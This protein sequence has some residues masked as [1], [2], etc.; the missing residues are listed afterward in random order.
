MSRHA[1][2]SGLPA[3]DE[4][5]QGIR[6]GDNVVWKVEH[7]ED[8]LFFA[9]SF[10]RQSLQARRRVVYL[11]FA[12]H[13][14][15][16]ADW[17]DVERIELDPAP[18]FDA[19]SAELHRIITDHGRE[20]FYV[21]DNLSDLAVT[22]ATDEMLSNFFS[23]TCP[24]LFELDTVAYFA[25]TRG[26]HAGRTVASIRETTQLL[27]D[28]FHIGEA[29][30]LHPL[31][32]WDRY[33]PT[34]FLPHAVNGE[35]WTPVLHS[36]EATALSTHAYS[37]PLRQD[38]SS[39]APWD[40]VY[41]KLSQYHQREAPP[42]LQQEIA[43][44]E[45]ELAI[46]LLGSH[47][48]MHELAM[49]FLGRNELLAIRERLIGSGRIGGKATGMLVA[50]AIL[51]ANIEDPDLAAQLEGHDS[52]YIGSDVF[53]TFLVQNDLFRL[54]LRMT[55]TS[56][57]TREEF[58]V[59]ET[60]FL[61]GRFPE[62]IR[63]QFRHML[64][65]Y[66]QAPIIV[67]SSSLLEDSFGNAFAGKYRS[68]FLANQGEPEERLDQFERQVKLVYASALNPDALAYRKRHGLGDRDEQMAILVQRVSGF[69]LRRYFF[70]C[71]AGVAFS[72][73]MY[74]WADCIDPARGIIRLV[75][76]L[77]TRAVDR[78]GGEYPRMVAISHPQLR[79]EIG[80]GIARY[81]QR[82][83]DLLDLEDNR[84]VTLPVSRM[85]RQDNFPHLHLLVS[86]IKEGCL[87]DPFS[88]HVDMTADALVPTLNNLL[89][90]TAIV[91]TIDCLLKHLE[92][93]YGHPVEIEF[94][95]E[96]VH[97]KTVRINLLQCRPL[98]F[99]NTAGPVDLPALSAERM[100][101]R[102][103]RIM[104]WGKVSGI[105]YVL[106]IDPTCYAAIRDP[107][108]KP[109][110]GRVV[111][112]INRHPCIEKSRMLM[113]GPG[114]WGSSN[115]DLG[116]NVGYADINSAAVLVELAQHASGELPELSY[117][118]HFFQDLVEDGVIYMP[119][120]PDDPKS[121]FNR[122]FFQQASNHLEVMFPDL[123]QYAAYIK[124]IDLD[125]AGQTA[126]V[127]T[128]P[129]V[130]AGLCFLDEGDAVG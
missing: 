126:S 119:V 42:E 17:P 127:I 118:T 71:L 90:R 104:S 9:A 78:I 84:L 96:P 49:K 108:I 38:D 44:L 32:V 116:V 89:R 60:R 53:F 47:P 81:A 75:L 83:M 94:T 115:I 33:S 54:R 45:R 123:A 76:G 93:A 58:R 26:L 18:G 57:I 27:I 16:L 77:G 98:W 2:A 30:Y 4:V 87:T 3:L 67:R 40:S 88:R 36:A 103:E 82:G 122:T 69:R 79:P 62:H 46:M 5:V 48:Q 91:E 12:S 19:F 20:C 34:M 13:P 50:R 6:L 22:W 31:K 95:A 72:K 130:R 15:V 125:E 114:R 74:V 41:R 14:P 28:V 92:K 68:E 37:H 106:Y 120:Y 10:A 99:P 112:A 55:I 35:C 56:Q 23:V 64:S 7:L 105:R 65:Y 121:C 73:N 1:V 129:G 25:L 43:A 113:I 102:A 70:P 51:A 97:D 111:G 52:F 21:F 109:S 128:D 107:A 85:L 61:A 101:F 11:R 117:G 63:E 29:M 80:E 59:V 39:I 66:G 100:L 124:L 86:E 8:Y 24:Y 110:L